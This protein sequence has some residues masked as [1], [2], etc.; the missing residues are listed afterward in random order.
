MYL[1][2]MIR[3]D[4]DGGTTGVAVSDVIPVKEVSIVIHTALI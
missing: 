2:P 1:K 3:F 4:Y